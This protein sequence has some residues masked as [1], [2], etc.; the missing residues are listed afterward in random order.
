MQCRIWSEMIVG[1][2]RTSLED[3]P[4]SSMFSRASSGKKKEEGNKSMAEA[5]TQAAV[6]ISSALSP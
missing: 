2:I 1:G 6:A 4:T 5:L 3:P